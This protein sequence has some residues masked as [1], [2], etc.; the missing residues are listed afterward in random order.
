MEIRIGKD[1]V[2][3]DFL[4]SVRADERERSKLVAELMSAIE[5]RSENDSVNL[6]NLTFW[7]ETGSSLE[8][9]HSPV[10]KMLTEIIYSVEFQSLFSTPTLF[11]RVKVD[12]KGDLIGIIGPDE[13]NLKDYYDKTA[14]F[15]E[16]LDALV[17]AIE[18][19]GGEASFNGRVGFEHWIRFHG[20]VLPENVA[21]V[22]K[23]LFFLKWKWP[24]ADGLGNYWEAI[25]GV[26]ENSVVLTT[27]QYADIR[28]LTAQ[29]LPD[30]LGVL[31]ALY[32]NG[33]PNPPMHIDEDSANEVLACVLNQPFSK[34]LAQQ[35]IDA[36]GWYGSGDGETVDDADLAQMLVT[37]I[38]VD[39]DPL[40][41]GHE[42]RN[43]VGTYNLY[44]PAI[45]ADQPMELVREGFENYLIKS[46]RVSQDLSPLAAHLLLG[47][48]APGFVVKFLPRDLTVGSI[49][50]LTFVQAVAL[51]ELNCKGASRFMTYEQVMMFSDM[52]AI[53][54]QFGQLQGIAAMDSIFDWALINEVISVEELE[55]F[56]AEAQQRALTSYEDFMEA[57]T[58]TART[59]STPLPSRRKLALA[60]LEKAAPGCY[61]LDHKVLRHE[62]DKFSS[63][64]KMS[65][66]DL[67]I[68]GELTGR[69]WDW[70][71]AGSLYDTYPDLKWLEPNQPVFERAVIQYESNLRK[72]MNSNIKLAISKMPIE[73]R[74]VF[75]TSEITFFTVRVSVSEKIFEKSNGLIGGNVGKP[76]WM[77]KQIKRDE[78]TGRYA[79][80][81]CA[82]F[83]DSELLCYEMYYLKGT[84]RL[85]KELG[86][87]ISRSGLMNIQSRID[88]KGDLKAYLPAAGFYKNPIDLDCYTKGTAPVAKPYV[89][90][91]LDKL[92]VLAA[93][94]NPGKT[95]ASNF[96]CFINPHIHEI[97]E[98]L[99]R[100]HPIASITEIGIAATELTE[101]EQMRDKSEKALA[102]IIDL[103]IP[104]KKCI[105]DIRSGD[106]DRLEE[107][108]WGCGLDLV[109]IVSAF[110]GVP[111]KAVH[112][113][114][115]VVPLSLKIARLARLA[116][117]LT[118]SVFN[119]V[120]GLPT[121][122]YK[123][124][125]FALKGVQRLGT[126][127]LKLIE[128]ATFQMRRLTG[129]AHSVDLIQ[130]SRR[131]DFH[132]GTWRPI[133]GGSHTLSV[134]AVRQSGG[135]YAFNQS[136][137]AWGRRLAD[138]AVTQVRALP[139][140]RRSLPKG[141]ARQIIQRSLPVANR[142]VDHA[143]RALAMPYFNRETELTINLLI[144]G[145]GSTREKM[146]VVLQAAKLN[147]GVTVVENFLLKNDA[148][149]R[150]I[151]ELSR[152][153]YR[154]W[155]GADR[156]RTQAFFTVDTQNLVERFT[157][158][159]SRFGEVAD[160]L[161]HEM[162]KTELT[163]PDAAWALTG[164]SNQQTVDVA[165]L[166]NLAKGFL[167]KSLDSSS[168]FDNQRAASNADSYA[169]A[170]ALL[171][172]LVTHEAQ[173][174][175]NIH[176][177]VEVMGK[178]EGRAIDIPV[179]INLNID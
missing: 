32:R 24:E 109:G 92:G 59:F 134:C 160:D 54:L 113:G 25:T 3:E 72:A 162:F 6:K 167:I 178:Y 143:L 169:V 84:C 105:E 16:T 18:A 153:D 147:F 94:V 47:F 127:G 137:R 66:L 117:Q 112:I 128:G 58:H 28:A 41:G 17:K 67:H 79:V 50:W 31:E 71:E 104:F 144:G 76:R 43:H 14:T 151:I 129:K 107:G 53:S 152:D 116:M 148:T 69:E 161:I 74:G 4:L 97:A 145:S 89:D 51:I 7:L 171:S 164:A 133:E 55:E 8:Y 98:F 158:A 179:L 156:P 52:D 38:L 56:P 91:I 136:G 13:F 20:H 46:G 141:F 138:F 48:M 165:P 122:A 174:K 142:K 44:A 36:L 123:G 83:G 63:S 139:K 99:T 103:A 166:L 29:L 118:I 146:E 155:K 108:L 87:L 154:K 157:S 110:M 111:A 60:A 131:A 101:R 30:G 80:V 176:L 62:T 172:Q 81:M 125:R 61:F 21:Q 88:F 106:K 26:D 149:G 85:N 2:A 75:E 37:A 168:Y 100:H 86:S 70:R 78:A 121:A 114:T 173:A 130:A 170:T 11:D 27:Q 35:Y 124:M 68:E 57:L 119:P 159:K 65:I 177:M 93:P 82:P 64:Y 9:M 33:R 22:K 96:Q 77:E 90:T 102:Y 5:G 135:W 140:L 23:L 40:I 1:G 120:D 45:A 10:S 115:K 73:H 34:K 19:I 175:G 49:N 12:S 126:P 150:S 39:L 163:M 95:K 132:V 15:S 42:R